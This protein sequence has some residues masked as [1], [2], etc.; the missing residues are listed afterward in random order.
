MSQCPTCGSNAHRIPAETIH[1]AYYLCELC[2]ES[3]STQED[4]METPCDESDS[5]EHDPVRRPEEV[6]IN[7]RCNA[8]GQK[9]N[10]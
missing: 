3:A 4:L 1:S 2:Q 5:R 9:F 7:H 6:R 10:V 8:C